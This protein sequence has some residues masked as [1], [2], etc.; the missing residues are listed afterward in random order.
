[1]F[2]YLIKF[3]IIG[4]NGIV[5]IGGT[6]IVAILLN[7]LFEYWNKTI[8]QKHR[9]YDKINRYQESLNI[10]FRIKKENSNW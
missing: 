1:M 2:V 3:N 6:V 9:C 5:F 4:V 7:H 8:S 10:Y